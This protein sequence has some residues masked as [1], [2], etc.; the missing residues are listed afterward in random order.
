MFDTAINSMTARH[1]SCTE[2]RI[3]MVAVRE[4]A[5]KKTVGG[6]DVEVYEIL[7]RD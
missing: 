5:G 4:L 7:H 1:D 3:M 6:T 2:L